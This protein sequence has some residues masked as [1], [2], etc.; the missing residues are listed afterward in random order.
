MSYKQSGVNSKLAPNSTIAV[1]PFERIEVLD[2]VHLSDRD[3]VRAKCNVRIGPILISDVK[4]VLPVLNSRIFVGWPSR[5][6]GETWRPLI[7]I[8]SPGL[9][10]A[11]YNAVISAWRG[12]GR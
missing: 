7:Q 9:E 10:H 6:D 12:G 4:I 3:T 1:D 11:I 8:L 2:L 5:R